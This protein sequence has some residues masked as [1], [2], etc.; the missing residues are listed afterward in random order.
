MAA[1]NVAAACEVLKPNIRLR[2]PDDIRYT[3]DTRNDAIH[4][5]VSAVATITPATMS[6]L[7]PLNSTLMS[8]IIPTPIRKNGMNIA[9]PTKSIR[10]ISGDE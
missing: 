3:F 6:E 2:S 7:P 10:R 5:P 1:A 4:L 9:F 8:I